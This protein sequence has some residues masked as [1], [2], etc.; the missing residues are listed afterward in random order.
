MTNSKTN[1][2]STN[3][4]NVPLAACLAA[5]KPLASVGAHLVRLSSTHWGL[6]G[7]KQAGAAQGK[8]PAA[9]VMELSKAGFID[10][11][12]R[13]RGRLSDEGRSWLIGQLSL[14]GPEARRQQVRQMEP[15]TGEDGQPA[16]LLVNLS[17]SPLTWLYRRRG[18]DGE[19]LISEAEYEAG[20][21]L[22]RDFT[23]AGLTPRVTAAW[24]SA[25]EGGRRRRRK[26]GLGT[27]HEQEISD[28]AAAARA[29]V[30]AALGTVGPE[31]ETILLD[32][33]CFLHG[34][35]DSEARYGWPRRSAK[36]VLK[37]AL[38]ALAR[39]YAHGGVARP[40]R[41]GESRGP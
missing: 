14:G 4:L 23:T 26:E 19:A 10:L 15:V 17:E 7:R 5:L 30:S 38:S 37:L 6:Y 28:T 25:A 16:D 20:E 8:L 21:R 1:V 35:E 33:C 36:L 9:L 32:T 11:G 34:V 27:N 3:A 39:H 22:R 41:P 24:S 40:P 13:G 2:L 31:F 12:A 18:R 29:R